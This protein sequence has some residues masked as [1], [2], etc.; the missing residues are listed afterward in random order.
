MAYLH[1][2]EL[3]DLGYNPK[4]KNSHGDPIIE[5][6][7]KKVNSIKAVG[8]VSVSASDIDSSVLNKKLRT[9]VNSKIAQYEGQGYKIT[10]NDCL[11]FS[12]DILN[13]IFNSG[14]PNPPKD[15]GQYET[16]FNGLTKKEK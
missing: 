9:K 10:V 11:V 6:D 1:T 8:A 12:L 7:R 2:G 15:D 16:W 5:I 14:I 4:N 3:F 13:S